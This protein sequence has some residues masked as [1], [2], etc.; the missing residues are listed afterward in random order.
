MKTFIF[1]LRASVAECEIL[2]R[3]KTKVIM[4]CTEGVKVSVPVA[5][6]RPFVLANGI[7]GRFKLV[8]D[9]DN[10][11]LSFGRL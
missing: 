1:V 10:K 3:G 5:R 8:I 2:Y 11:V 9:N 6:I 7:E 4:T